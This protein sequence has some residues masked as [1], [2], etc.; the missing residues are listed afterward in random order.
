MANRKSPLS[1][2]LLA[3]ACVLL[4]ANAGYLFLQGKRGIAYAILGAI[5]VLVEWFRQRDT[6]SAWSLTPAV[7]LIAFYVF[8]AREV[9]TRVTSTGQSATFDIYALYV[10]GSFG[11][12]PSVWVHHWI[13]KAAGSEL[14]FQTVYEAL[15][16]AIAAAYAFNLASSRRWRVFAMM[17]FVGLIGVQCY[18]L[19]PI[20]GPAY[21]PFGNECF[22]YHGSCSLASFFNGSPYMISIDNAWSRNGMPSLHMS[23]ALLAWWACRNRSRL[24]WIMLGFALLTA[25]AT[26]AYGEHYLIDLAAACPFSVA[27]WFLCM[28]ETPMLQPARI[29]PLIAGA[30]GYLAWIWA[31]RFA[32]Q[33]FQV[34]RLIPWAA[35]AVSVGFVWIVTYAGWRPARRGANSNGSKRFR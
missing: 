13:A 1:A 6:I 8:R 5:I 26:L 15:P 29:L 28:E 17:L 22:Y 30:F 34:S 10:D 19:L 20:C 32:P 21:L 12:Q 18:R 14:L 3:I 27:I 25:V 33:V 23:W 31:V 2:P 16:A 35:L 24:R 9:L 11:F 4:A 7:V